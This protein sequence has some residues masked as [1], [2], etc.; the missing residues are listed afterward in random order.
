VTETNWAGNVAYIAR[1]I[2]RP[3]TLEQVQEIV[4]AAANVRVLGSRHTFNTIADSAEL[5]S[6]SSMPSDVIVD[7]KTKTVS[8]PAGLRYGELAQQLEAE[9]LA[10]HN[11]ASLPH[12]SVGG[13]IA[14]GT[15]GSGDRNGNLSTAVA[16]VQLV[17]SSGELLEFARGDPE[18]DGVVVNLGALGA[19]TRLR[20]DFE[21]TYLARQTVYEGLDWHAFYEHFDA[22]T[23]SGYSVSL[24]TTWAPAS[25]EQVWVKQRESEARNAETLFGARAAQGQL[26]PAP[27]ADPQ[28]CTP[29]L[30]EPGVWWQRLPHFRLEFEPSLGDELQTEYMV[31][32]EHA[33]AAID[34]VRGL[35]DRIRPLLVVSEIRTVAADG[36]WMSPEFQRDT[37]C[38]HFTW[39]RRQPE[40]EALLVDLESELAPLDARP[41]W[42]KLFAAR[43]ES[44]AA[45]YPRL[46]QFLRLVDQLDPRGVFSNTWFRERVRF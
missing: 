5:I 20:L 4:R 6:L 44:I 38:L 24:L 14:T 36:L 30:G 22:V 13:A 17:T 26:H 29:Q 39:Q 19:V 33:V 10:L 16:G 34:V 42:G 8:V 27:G 1:R 46:P 2:H 43:A 28:N 3:T 35:A 7:S 40:V 9:G 37:V 11:T 15:H 18:F 32:R 31:S 41:H 25:I 12:V 23:S 45:M 21:P